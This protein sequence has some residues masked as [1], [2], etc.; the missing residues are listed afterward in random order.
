MK[1]ADEDKY[2]ITLILRNK[3]GSAKVVYYGVPRSGLAADPYV[4]VLLKLHDSIVM[5]K[6]ATPEEDS[7]S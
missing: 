2:R 3:S 5:G 1:D 7:N 4:A 6:E